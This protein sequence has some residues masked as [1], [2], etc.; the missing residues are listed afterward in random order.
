MAHALAE[1]HIELE[2]CKVPKAFG[3]EMYRKMLTVFYVEE[4]MKT[5]AKQGKCSFVASSRGHE[6]IQ[7]GSAL[8]LKGG[9]DWLFTYYRSKATAIGAGVPLKAFSSAC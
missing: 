5:F 7:L 4:R 8:L 6:A 2:E 9:Y 3:L 1:R